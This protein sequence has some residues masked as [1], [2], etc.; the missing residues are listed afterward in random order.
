MEVF[1]I[2]FTKWAKKLEASGN[3]ARWNSAGNK[4][5]YTAA[6][7]AL[8]SLENIVH[9]NGRGLNDQ[10]KVMVINIPATVKTEEIGLAQLPEHWWEISH[11]P[12]CRKIGDQWL[13]AG[14]T[15]VLKIPSA[16]VLHEFNYLLNPNHKDFKKIKLVRIENFRFDPR[17]KS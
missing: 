5:I 14:K 10:F 6:S 2:V 12:S 7:R 1:R 13:A 16:I 11:Y 17:I 9:R 3:A 4:V 15:A 8:A